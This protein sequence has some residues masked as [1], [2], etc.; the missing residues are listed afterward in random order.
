[1]HDVYGVDLSSDIL[2]ARSWRWLRV[3]IQ[4]LL[5]AETRLARHFRPDDEQDEQPQY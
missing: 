5:S 2:T 4:G 3:R 1:M